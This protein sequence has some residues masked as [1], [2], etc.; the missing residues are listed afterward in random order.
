VEGT[1]AAVLS[2]AVYESAEVTV[3]LERGHRCRVPKSLIDIVAFC[4]F[5]VGR[6]SLLGS[7][8]TSECTNHLVASVIADAPHGS[9]D[10]TSTTLIHHL[11]LICR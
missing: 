5:G 4:G 8:T 10:S 7:D 6:A 1:S 9:I 11:A 3:D 2:P